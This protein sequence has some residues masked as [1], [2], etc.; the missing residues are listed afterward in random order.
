MKLIDK[1]AKKVWSC[2]K[3]LLKMKEN[4]YDNKKKKKNT[5][6]PCTKKPVLYTTR[7]S[8]I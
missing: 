2:S 1:Q 3:R 6:L 8:G 4:F 5:S 7:K